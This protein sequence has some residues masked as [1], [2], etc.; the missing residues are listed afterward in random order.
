MNENR[1]CYRCLL[2]ESGREDILK[3]IRE[4]ILRIPPAEKTGDDEYRRRL[5]I[6]GK[7]EFLA[8]GTCL[9]C[10]CYPEFR[11]AFVKNGCPVKKWRN[12]GRENE[13]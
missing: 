7:C 3:D 6:C 4:R 1:V 11:G 12:S 13:N 5:E 2:F 8:D 9:K 10:G